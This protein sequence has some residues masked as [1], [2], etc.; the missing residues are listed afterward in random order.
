MAG[1]S[2]VAARSARLIPTFSPIAAWPYRKAGK[3]KG[4][5]MLPIRQQSKGMIDNKTGR[6]E[7]LKR[8]LAEAHA[9][10][11]DARGRQSELATVLGVSRHSVSAWFAAEPKKQP[12]AEQA[13]AMLEFLEQ[14]RRGKKRRPALPVTVKQ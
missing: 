5:H 10:C 14:Q 9:W 3:K 11:K 7:R 1:F 2:P 4:N 8:L 13:L 6:P 12:T